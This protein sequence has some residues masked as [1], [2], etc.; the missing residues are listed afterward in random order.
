MTVPHRARRRTGLRPRRSEKA[1]H[2]PVV[3][4]ER[5]PIMRA[6]TRA[7]A[8]EQ[9]G[10]SAGSSCARPREREG[11][12]ELGD[13][14]LDCARLLALE[15][16]R[17]AVLCGG[18]RVEVAV[19]VAVDAEDGCGRGGPLEEEAVLVPRVRR[20]RGRGRGRVDGRGRD[21]GAG[22]RADARDGL[23]VDEGRRERDV[24]LFDGH[25]AADELGVD[26]EF[27]R[28]DHAAR[29]GEEEGAGEEPDGRGA[30]V[31]L[32]VA[33]AALAPRVGRAGGWAGAG[34]VG[35]ILVVAVVDVVVREVRGWAR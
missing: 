30:V 9:E 4:A 27:G 11:T 32:E 31:P 28:D 7:C 16:P 18:G 26:F 17:V 12:H 10:V 5:T 8:R 23:G 3:R 20:G 21:G 14:G 33:D 1:P 13:G 25:G 35:G 34:R 22:D 2:Q 15:A 24:G 19:R 29:H 6:R